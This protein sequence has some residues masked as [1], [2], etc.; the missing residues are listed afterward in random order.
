M[1]ERKKFSRTPQ[2]PE[3]AAADMNP[4][5][6]KYTK[7]HE[8]AFPEGDTAV[9]GISDFAVKTLTDLVFLELPQVGTVATAGEAFGEIESVKAVGELLAPVSGEIVEVHSE[10]AD[11]LDSIAS[12]PFGNGWLIKI[13]MND[14]AEL[15]VLLDRPAYEKWCDED[16][17]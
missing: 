3:I 12:D 14:P 15:D 5:E 8:W 1:L 16:G 2:A 17:H 11:G 7:S 9:I 6:L 13:R 4:N 10:I